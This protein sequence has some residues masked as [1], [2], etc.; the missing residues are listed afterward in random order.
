MEE[1]NRKPMGHSTTEPSWPGERQEHSRSQQPVGEW[2]TS[3]ARG[4]AETARE[5]VEQAAGYVH[6]A[7]EQTRSYVQ[8]AV[9]QTR[10]KVAEYRDRGF[11]KVKD[12]VVTYTRQQPVT[13][14]LIAVGAGLMLGWLTSVGRK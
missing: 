3:Q 4:I 10:E 9:D 7:M 2:A 1:L 14:L 13:A 6:G 11:E 8:G 12:D 5:G